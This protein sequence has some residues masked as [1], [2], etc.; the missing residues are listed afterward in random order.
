MTNHKKI[1]AIISRFDGSCVLTK[2]NGLNLK[3]GSTE[4]RINQIVDAVH[5]EF[6]TKEVYAEIYAPCVDGENIYRL[7][8]K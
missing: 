7:W 3:V 8:V 2:F 1:N 5:S 4:N 6:K